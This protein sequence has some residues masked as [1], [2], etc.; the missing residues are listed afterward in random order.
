MIQTQS[1]SERIGSFIKDRSALSRLIVLNVA[2][3][4]A[5]NLIRVIAFLF[6]TPGN[7]LE[8]IWLINIQKWL[9]VPAGFALWISKPWT[10]FTYMFLH[11]DF[12][13]LFFNMIWLYWFGKIFL[14]FLSDRRMIAVYIIGGLSGAL[15][16]MLAFNFFPAFTASLGYAL[17]LGASASVLAIVVATSMMVPEYVVNLLFIGKVKIKY[18]ALITIALDVFM[19]RSSNAGGHF[20]HLG[21][22]VAGLLY[23]LAMRSKVISGLFRFSD[24]KVF[25]MF[26]K[27]KIKTVYTSSKPLSDEDYNASKARNQKRIDGIL[28]KIAKSGYKSLTEEEKEFLF[29]FSNK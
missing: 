9:A 13:H 14:E 20:A 28:D 24:N 19:L 5:I 25:G 1:V 4:L 18:I 12:W 6:Q 16:F 3:W 15:S 29:K 23:I 8:D 22:A 2:I 11:I 10:P 7:Q 27:S 26:R 17:A 21:G